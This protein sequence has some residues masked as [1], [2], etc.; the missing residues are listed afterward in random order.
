M[1]LFNFSAG[2]TRQI[3]RA[4]EFVAHREV[5]FDHLSARTLI[6]KTENFEDECQQV[7]RYYPP[8]GLESCGARLVFNTTR[9]GNHKILVNK[10]GIEG[11]SYIHTLVT[12]LV[13]LGNLSR[14]NVDHGNVYRL[15]PEQAI[16][17]HYYEFLLWSRFQAMRIATRAHALVTWHEVNGEAPPADGRYQFAQIAFPGEGVRA[18]LAGM[19][20]AG[21]LAA[22]REDLWNLLEEL[23]L[24]FGRLA[25]YQ[26]EAQPSD[27]DDRFP[28]A[29][30]EATVGLDNCLAFY[31][32]LLR[33]R[34][35]PSWLAEK[36]ALRR[37]VVAMQ[38]QG[39]Q[40]YPSGN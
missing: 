25:F 36:Q 4:L 37:A 39:K 22:W 13:H 15:E 35:Y 28:A 12:E 31:A 8:L 33:A 23:S 16:A 40:R 38:E 18:A 14:Y 29:L 1:E 11:L 5:D 20:Q 17:D 6:V 26:Q 3:H 32:G 21:T 7:A 2:E 10:E 30:I 34:D 27:L 19:A 24:Y 9:D